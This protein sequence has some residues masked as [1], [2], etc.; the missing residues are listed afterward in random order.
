MILILQAAFLGVLQTFTEIFPFSNSAHIILLQNWFGP[1]KFYPAYDV[2]IDCGLLL[3]FFVYFSKD[4]A[5]IMKESPIVLRWPFSKDR[6]DFF[7]E[8]PYAMWL[9]LL[10]GSTLVA[11]FVRVTFQDAGASLYRWQVALGMA[12]VL[13]GLVLLMSRH[14]ENGSR[15]IFEMNHQDA[16]LIGLAQGLAVFPGISRLGAAFLAAL[17]L[18]LERKE[19]ARYSF[20]LGV[21]YTILAIIYKF[22]LG[23]HFRE[24]DQGA[25]FV[26]FIAAAASGIIFLTLVM[27]IVERGLFFA[28][29]LYCVGIGFFAVLQSLIKVIF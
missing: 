17:A 28:T 20:I 21:P 26:V 16:F 5:E 14:Y 13:M 18:G 23:P 25:L 1:D 19:A 22:Y 2:M 15:S 10:V 29:G 24:A 12:W 27:R 9:T 11:V 3:S 4:M 7:L 6:G 8:Y